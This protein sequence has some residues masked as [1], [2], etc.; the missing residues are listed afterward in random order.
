M[1]PDVV[2]PL[3]G[4]RPGILASSQ[5]GVIVVG[6]IVVGNTVSVLPG[7]GDASVPSPPNPAPAPTDRE[8]DNDRAHNATTI[9][10]KSARATISHSSVGESAGVLADAVFAPVGGE[11]VA[12]G[13]CVPCGGWESLVI[14]GSA[15]SLRCGSIC[16]VIVGLGLVVAAVGVEGGGASPRYCS[17]NSTTL[18][19]HDG[20]FE[21]PT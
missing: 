12:V 2:T 1:S 3:V 5:V 15:T 6:V 14:L 7:A 9:A 18:A 19:A 17:I 8:G 20:E 10:S 11:W 16:G 4:V 13:C 21:V